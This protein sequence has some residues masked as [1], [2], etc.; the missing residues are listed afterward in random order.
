M[1]KTFK[2]SPSDLT[3]LWDEC[4]KCAY[5]KIRHGVLRPR[6]IMPTI[7]VKIDSIMKKYFEGKSP[8]DIEPS[9][10]SGR[11]EFGDRWVQSKV[12]KDRKTGNQL[13]IK[14]KTDTVLGFD[15]KT[16]GVVDFKTSTVKE[17]NV[18]RYSRQLHSYS[19]C[20]ENAESGKPSLKPISRLGLF[21]VEPE[22]LLK[23]DKDQYLFKNKV[24]WQEI[25]RDDEGFFEFL[26]EVVALLSSD[27]IPQP[28]GNCSHCNYVQEINNF[29]GHNNFQ[30]DVA[31]DPVCQK[32]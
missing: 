15:D 12:F 27:K 8:S 17:S 4:P 10:P 14:G 20:L 24:K 3:F 9:L 13:F 18:K 1:T 5:L 2:L 23:D 19:L 32:L 16:Y 7:F 26:R 21:V 30:P 11:I 29:E 6:S 28:G 22:E 31:L 25:P